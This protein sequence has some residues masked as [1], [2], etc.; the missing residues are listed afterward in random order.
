MPGKIPRLAE[1][2]SSESVNSSAFPKALRTWVKNAGINN[3]L[4]PG[5]TSDD[6]DCVPELE[7]EVRK[8]R[9]ANT[10]LRQA[11]A[12]FAAELDRPFR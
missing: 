7:Q 11:S 4:K 2:P 6:A 9:W 3:G 5:T 8:L 10:I 12:F 1:V